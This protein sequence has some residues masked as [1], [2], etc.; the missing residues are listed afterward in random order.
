MS[1][2]RRREPLHERLAREGGLRT[3]PP[4]L[5]PRPPTLETGIHGLQRPRAWDATVTA[6]VDGIEAD[7]ATFVALPDG[8]LLV[9]DGPDSELGGLA[10][11]V[12]QELRPP[13]RAQAV[14]RGETLWAVAARRLEV[15]E[16]PG[17]PD[18]ETLDVVRA[19]DAVEVRVD[20]ERIFGSIPALEQR[21]EREGRDYAVHAERLDGDL[22][23]VRA[24]AL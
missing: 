17:A 3:G 19:G 15:V 12:E 6:Q 13:Y 5:D 14:R 24:A 22:W 20:G 18:G 9:E 4:P 21:G 11:A 16:L 1:L 8:S 2:F 7:E 23:E 10:E